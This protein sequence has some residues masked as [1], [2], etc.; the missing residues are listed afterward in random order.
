MLGSRE[1]PDSHRPFLRVRLEVE[2]D[3]RRYGAWGYVMRAAEGGQ[4]VI[5]CILV[6][7]G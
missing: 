7:Q 5:G 2:A 3:S 6:R 4:P 1:G